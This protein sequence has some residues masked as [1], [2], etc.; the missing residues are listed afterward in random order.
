MLP[1][2]LSFTAGLATTLGSILAVFMP[3]KDK[4]LLGMSLSFSAGVMIYISFMELLPQGLK[5]LP[6]QY[7]GVA[8]FFIG[9]FTTILIDKVSPDMS[10]EGEGFDQRLYS[11]GWV[12]LLAITLHNLPEGVAIFSVAYQDT[13]LSIP[14]IIAMAIHNIPEGLAISAPLY[15]ATGNKTKAIMLGLFSGLMEPIAGIGGYF[16]LKDFIG[17]YYF[18]YTF[19]FISGIMVFLAI[20]QLLPEARK[21]LDHHTAGYSFIAGMIIMAITILILN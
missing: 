16:L 5:N 7:I 10:H 6:H 8:L 18:Q 13:N 11:I 2:I 20:D 21:N 19:C 17:S 15:F 12:S 4:R 1:F 14:I 3:I 9:I